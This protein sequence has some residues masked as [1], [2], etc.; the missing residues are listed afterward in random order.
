MRIRPVAAVALGFIAVVA[1]SRVSPAKEWTKE[2]V[3]AGLASPDDGKVY[4]A[5][6][7][8]EKH[9][10]DDAGL[11]QK[12]LSLLGDPRPKVKRKAARVFGALGAKL[13][14]AQVRQVQSLLAASDKD[15]VID[16]LKALRGLQNRN[17]FAPIL[18]LLQ[19][20]DAN[21]KRDSCRTLAVIADKSVIPKIEPLLNDPDKKVRQDAEEALAA[22]KK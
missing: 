1:F 18:P 9:F 4:D 5:L 13:S 11:R 2:D 3:A 20:P 22:L 12:A 16:G 7:A 21:I 19:S 6:Q 14:D 15:S 10:S 17:D 8:F